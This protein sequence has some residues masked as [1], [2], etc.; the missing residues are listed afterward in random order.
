MAYKLSNGD[1]ARNLQEQV[2][3]NKQDILRHYEVERV[4]ADW[5]IRVIGRLDEWEVPTGTF[6]YGDAYAVGP[7]GGP[8]VFYIYTRGEP[9]YW[10]DYGAISIVGP[11]G[12]AGPQGE[13][14]ETGT[15]T[16][17]YASSNQP[18]GPNLAEGDMWLNITNSSVYIFSNQAWRYM[19]SI[20]GAA[21]PQGPA[22]PTGPR[23]PQGVQGERGPRGYSTITK[24][25]G[26]L[27]EGSIISD[28]YNPATQP[29]NATVLMP[30]NGE[31][32]AWV[33]I[34][35]IWTDAGPYS[36]GSSVYVN[37]E[38]E[39]SFN[40]DTKVD[41]L[42]QS[43]I[44]IL[45]AQ[46]QGNDNVSA[47]EFTPDV[48]P[49]TVVRRMPATGD[50][51]VP[52]TP[53]I[54]VAAA[55][56]NYVDNL[57]IDSETITIATNDEGKKTANLAADLVTQLGRAIYAPMSNPT[58]NSVPVIQPSGNRTYLKYYTQ[59]ATIT[60]ANTDFINKINTNFTHIL[61]PAS[62]ATE[63]TLQLGTTRYTA[64]QRADFIRIGNNVTVSIYF[65]NGNIMTQTYA[66][67][68]ITPLLASHTTRL[69][70]TQFS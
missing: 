9:D 42:S 49:L 12:P 45:Y 28:T 67:S 4:L 29:D 46:F 39:Q 50:I 36:G 16:R 30:V 38:F 20:K 37:G 65:T 33:I 43:N 63:L 62:T 40:A 11:Q 15:S 14:G 3:K 70:S 31:M 69:I 58:Y 54:P 56:K 13:T 53:Q 8:F 6:N 57:L 55:S 41:K 26:E 5:G 61:V 47:I 24:I 10:F 59:S 66:A 27:P 35:G 52:E 51:L 68:D 64:V 18:T 1:I 32:H 7:E 48:V 60:N 23:G 22:G 34:D 17:W 21:G 25:I 19:L 2:L 44:D